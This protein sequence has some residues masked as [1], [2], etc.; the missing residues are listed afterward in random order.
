M[1]GLILIIV[2]ISSVIISVLHFTGNIDWF[3]TLFTPK[4]LLEDSNCGTSSS[5]IPCLECPGGSKEACYSECRTRYGITGTCIN[6]EDTCPAYPCF[7]N[8]N[9][10]CTISSPDISVDSNIPTP[11]P[12]VRMSPRIG[13]DPGTFSKA[14]TPDEWRPYVKWWLNT[15]DTLPPPHN[16]QS[17]R[18][19][20]Q[21]S[22]NTPQGTWQ[23]YTAS[24]LEDIREGRRTGLVPGRC[25][26]G[27]E[28]ITNIEECKEALVTLSLVPPDFD[29]EQPMLQ[30]NL[31]M[32]IN[33][34]NYME[35]LLAGCGE[36]NH[37]YFKS[38]CSGLNRPWGCYAFTPQPEMLSQ[39]IKPHDFG[40]SSCP[41]SEGSLQEKFPIPIWKQK[42][43][44]VIERGGGFNITGPLESRPISD[45]GF[46][47][48]R[49][50]NIN[51]QAYHPNILSSGC[52]GELNSEGIYINESSPTSLTPICFDSA[53]VAVCKLSS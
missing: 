46:K 8:C 12:W 23:R 52:S 51:D 27:T 5:P 53:T 40:C 11:I 36:N 15:E 48:C 3:S 20:P 26:E 29:M 44:N 1:L 35:S 7:N 22:P 47:E 21:A 41:L 38:N 17:R 39:K 31:N 42:A 45:C 30:N 10:S 18:E 6:L 9:A 13:G 34:I 16:V 25:R 49:M 43:G 24:E 2:V 4:N 28:P 19:D 50:D 32:Y 37:G 33:D 14:S